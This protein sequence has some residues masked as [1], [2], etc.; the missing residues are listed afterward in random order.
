[1]ECAAYLIMVKFAG[2]VMVFR[3]LAPKLIVAFTH[4][5]KART[6][7]QVMVGLT[8]SFVVMVLLAAMAFG[9]PPAWMVKL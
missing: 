4:H 2:V 7:P 6:L 9:D 1:M 5:Q 8:I 3:L